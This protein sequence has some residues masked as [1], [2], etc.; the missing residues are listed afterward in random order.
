[1]GKEVWVVSYYIRDLIIT[2]SV[3]WGAF[4][5]T[6]PVNELAVGMPATPSKV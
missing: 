4:L 3:E 6:Y 1:M 2:A 5:G